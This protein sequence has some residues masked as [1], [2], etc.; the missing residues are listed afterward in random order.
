MNTPEMLTFFQGPVA[1][2]L[3]TAGRA[4]RPTFT[5]LLGVHGI[6]GATE[7]RVVIPKALSEQ[8]L[9]DLGENPLASVTVTDITNMRSLQ[10]KGKILA[11]E[12]ASPADLSVVRAMFGVTTPTI[13]AFFGPGA[14]AGW[15]RVLIEPL[16]T[17]TL[18]YDRP[19]GGRGTL[20]KLPEAIKPCLQGIIPSWVATC[21]KEGVPNASV[22]SQVFF[23]DDEH[24][25]VSNQFFGKTARNLDQ[26][27]QAQI[28]VVDPADCSIWLLDV[29][30]VRRE[31]DGPLFQDMAMQLEA[32]ASM[33]GAQ[34]LFVLRSAEVCRVKRVYQLKEAQR[35]A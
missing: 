34:D 4:H 29:E 28:Q 11:T 12:A 1:A 25:A 27:P 31:S 5:R 15:G 21:N 33:M 6:E 32:I 3:G 7:L 19:W 26:N 35:P 14:A 23:V 24:V 30:L 20:M 10:F 13:A 22:I 17:L 18:N 8:P 2:G 16:V 9:T